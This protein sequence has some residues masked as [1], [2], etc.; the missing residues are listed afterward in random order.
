MKRIFDYETI[1]FRDIELNP[2][3]SFVCDGDSKQVKVERED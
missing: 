2:N 1:T 3:L